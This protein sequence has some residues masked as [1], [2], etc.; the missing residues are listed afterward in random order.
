MKV[1]KR[2]LGGLLTLSLLLALAG[3][4]FRAQDLRDWWMLRG[5]EPSARVQQIATTTTMTDYA[6]HLFYVYRPAVEP[7]KEFNADCTIAEASIVLGCYDGTGI[8]VYDVTDKRLSGVHEVTAAHEMLHAGYDRLSGSERERIDALTKAELAK[9]TDERLLDVIQSYR[10]RDPNVVPNELHSILAT[11]VRS[12]SPELET[13][14]KKYF[15]NRLAVVVLSEQ[16]EQVFTDDKEKVA[17]YDSELATLKLKIDKLEMDLSTRADQLT[18]DKAELDNLARSKRTSEYNAKVPSYNA[19][20]NAYNQDLEVYKG[21]IATYNQKVAE[22][23][24]LTVEQN[25]LIQS[26]DSKAQTL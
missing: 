8:Y 25:S 19:G 21:Y 4:I 15:T 23:N 10:S 22:R 3:I 24:A 17:A 2:V 16:Y 6:R 20:V 18:I 14:Y 7:A 26:L 11:E 13:Y 1:F 5:Y 12:I 9:I